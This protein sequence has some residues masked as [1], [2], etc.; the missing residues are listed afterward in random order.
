[1]HIWYINHNGDN[2]QKCGCWGM[3]KCSGLR[4]KGL[5]L[6]DFQVQ[7]LEDGKFGVNDLKINTALV[8]AGD[9]C[10]CSIALKYL[11]NSIVEHCETQPFS[12]EE[13]MYLKALW[14][15]VS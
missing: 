9:V 11:I 6:T 13:N 8:K 7:I 15:K 14:D 4:Q 2:K 3:T 5:S 1:M 12:F 10:T